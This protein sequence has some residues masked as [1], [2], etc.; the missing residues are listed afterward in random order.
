LASLGELNH[1]RD[2]FIPHLYKIDICTSPPHR[3]S[4][5]HFRATRC[6]YT[7][8]TS[9]LE[10]LHVLGTSALRADP[11][12]FFLVKYKM[13]F[14]IHTPILPHR[15]ST[16]KTNYLGFPQQAAHQQSQSH[17]TLRHI[18]QALPLAT[19]LSTNS[20]FVGLFLP[21][22]LS[23]LASASSKSIPALYLFGYCLA[24]LGIEWEFHLAASSNRCSINLG[25]G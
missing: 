1:N 23:I 7:N 8:S 4:L 11:V 12:F 17:L 10:E 9:F 19:K 14:V 2:E 13:M 21:N 18:T 3:D 22:W 20:S 6:P 24:K 16:A 15:R 5:H 25:G